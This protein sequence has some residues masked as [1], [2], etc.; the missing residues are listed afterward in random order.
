[1]EKGKRSYLGLALG[2]LIALT[3]VFS[4]P[5]DKVEA[6]TKSGWVSEDGN[7]AF[8][9]NGVKAKNAWRSDSRGWTYIG[10]DSKMV[11]SRWQK[12]SHGWTYIGAE[13]YMVT[14]QW[15]KDSHG[16]TY[17]GAD[18]YMV[19]N[20]WAKDS[21][22]WT[23]IGADGYMVT[24]QWAKDSQ[25][26]TY[27]GSNGY[28]VTNQWAKD[29]QG[30]TYIGA[31]GYMVTNQW[32]KD[33]HGWAYL[34]EDGY[35]QK[36]GTAF[37]TQ[38]EA[39]IGEDGYWTGKYVEELEVVV[40]S[41][42]N[43]T[44]IEITFDNEEVVE[45]ELEETLVHGENEVTFEYNGQE[46]TVTVEYEDP[47][48]VALEEATA[49]A[50]AAI[51]EI[52]EEITLE[53]AEAVE[54]ARAL[55]EAA[56][57]LD[58]D[59]EIEGLEVLEAAE[60]KI[61]ELMA[62]EEAVQELAV[63][64]EEVVK[65][66]ETESQ[67][68]VN[69]ARALVEALPEGE[70]KDDLVAR[71]DEVQEV[72]DERL[73]PY[74]VEID[75]NGGTINEEYLLTEVEKG[76]N[77]TLPYG[78]QSKLAREGYTLTGYTVEGTLIDA[79]G[80]AVTEVS[81]YTGTYTP[82]SDVKL[83]AN[84]EL[85]YGKFI[86]Y[87][88]DENP[89]AQKD[90]LTVKLIDEDDT[91]FE[92]T[93]NQYS[94]DYRRWEVENIP[95]GTYTLSIDGFI[96][97]EGEKS[98]QPDTN[99][100]FEVNENGT[101][102]V[103]FEFADDK[104]TTFIRYK[105]YGE[106]EQT[107]LEEAIAAAE[108]AIAGLPEELTLEDAEAV[109]AA[110]T[111]VEATLELDEDA[112]IENIE[113]LEAAENKIAEIESEAAEVA[114]VIAAIEGLTYDEWYAG[115]PKD[116]EEARAAYDALS[117][118]QQEK[119]T[120]FEDLLVAEARVGL[121]T[122]IGEILFKSGLVEDDYTEESWAALKTSLTD[123]IAERDSEAATVESLEEAQVD[124]QE[125][126]DAL[127]TVEEALEA[128]Y[129]VFKDEIGSKLSLNLT[130]TGTGTNQR[131]QVTVSGWGS[132]DSY[133][134]DEKAKDVFKSL[135]VEIFENEDSEEPLSTSTLNIGENAITGGKGAPVESLAKSI[136]LIQF[137]YW[138]FDRTPEEYP[139]SWIRT[140]YKDGAELGDTDGYLALLDDDNFVTATH[141]KLTIELMNGEKEVIETK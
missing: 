80:E 39:I 27:I 13:G 7:W 93:S 124:L 106:K 36:G 3:V 82:Q 58:E 70:A 96:I 130:E 86:V 76:Q 92:L 111:L 17:I 44:T 107:P 73:A 135:V 66:E 88:Y 94:G 63:A 9:D 14:N 136:D 87:L 81:R 32:A 117:E 139:I 49:A 121:N 123:V 131:Q 110:R 132:V 68:D 33:S 98:G 26:W 20:Q 47:A 127:V 109:T 112:E 50:E 138:G 28:M 25:G 74:I 53:D 90:N 42:I 62:K 75:T 102:T 6:A 12:D 35:W 89:S 99:S 115:F 71:L 69:I 37:D 120:N 78:F 56:L 45:I 128:E 5:T 104:P 59:A 38:G 46:F 40:V 19:T 24:N 91:E 60:A 31:D 11:K 10:N 22:G 125:A 30:W 61:A 4:Q 113:V 48:V 114:A 95:N 140:A 119:I 16:W 2:L 29:S 65:A 122:L 8:Y 100:K 77:Y 64:T 126:L 84:W 141:A 108:A 23:Y 129:S 21:Q 67:E 137:H 105:V 15:A 34:G 134:K 72:I 54:A 97:Q 103:E 83:T 101:A 55:V 57:E 85:T 52:P 41:A 133:L 118:E 116:V 79:N 43:A 51:A 1:M 18:G